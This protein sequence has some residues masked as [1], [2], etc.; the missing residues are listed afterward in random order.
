MTAIV[1]RRKALYGLTATAALAAGFGLPGGARA[2]A[3]EN[4]TEI[5]RK[6]KI[7]I[8]SLFRD[9][10]FDDLNQYIV[11]ARAVMIFPE[12]LKGGFI[13][14]GE[15]GY[16][17]LLVRGEDR[18]WS[19]PSFVTLAAG[20]IGFQI[21]GQVSEVVLTVM[22]DGALDSVLQK[23]FKFGADASIAVG[24]LGKG[25]EASSTLNFDADIYAFSRNVGLFGGGALEGAGLIEHETNNTA[26]YSASDATARRIV[27]E[28]RYYNA[29]AEPLRAALP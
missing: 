24:P 25:V 20:S 17:V 22:N 9:P 6:S 15:G 18:S 19:P 27:I 3:L 12:V 7:T 29:E 8:E 28:R 5:V 2:E 16:G 21:G 10:G 23:Q 26:F 11:N 1:T 4:A 14:G 13:I